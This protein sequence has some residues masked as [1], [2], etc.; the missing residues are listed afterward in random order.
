MIC[1]NN[2]S[3]GSTCLL[4]SMPM[5]FDEDKGKMEVRVVGNMENINCIN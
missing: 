3:D 2:K 5:L 1:L 4:T